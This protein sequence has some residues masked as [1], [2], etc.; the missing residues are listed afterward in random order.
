MQSTRYFCQILMKLNFIDRLSK[1][2]QISNFMKILPLAAELFQGDGR[3]PGRQTD[4][5]T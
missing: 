1:N 3:N 5:Q 4:T 2:A